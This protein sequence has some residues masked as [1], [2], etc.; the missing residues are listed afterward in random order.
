[1][2][3][4]YCIHVFCINAIISTLSVLATTCIL[5][6]GTLGFYHIEGMMVDDDKGDR[7]VKAFYCC[8]MTLTT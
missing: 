1:M 3:E 4:F 7:L 8:V 6:V 5:A 2:A